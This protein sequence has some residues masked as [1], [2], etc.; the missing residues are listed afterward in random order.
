[1]LEPLADRGPRQRRA[2]GHTLGERVGETVGYRVR[3]GSKVSRATR[4]EVV[5]E[6]I[7]RGRFST[8]RTDPASPLVLFDD[9]TSARSMP[10]WG[11]RWR[12]TRKWACARTCVSW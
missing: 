7:S 9:F 8:I 2:H 4:I 12:G 10:I 6:G 1:V 11:W 3:F 5:T